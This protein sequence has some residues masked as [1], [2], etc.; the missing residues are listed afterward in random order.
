[1]RKITKKIKFSFLILF[2]LLGTCGIICYYTFFQNTLTI[3]NNTIYSNLLPTN[4]FK[5][6]YTPKIKFGNMPITDI[7]KISDVTLNILDETNIK[8]TPMLLKAQRYYI[9]LNF[10]CSKLKYNF[11]DS[12]GSLIVNNESHT[13]S[14][15]QDTYTKDSINGSLRGNLINYNGDYYIGISDIEK[16]FGLTAVFDFESKHISLLP[17]NVQQPKASSIIYSRKIALLRF[18]DFTN[19]DS[20]AV[21][22]NQV[23]VKCMAD[24][25]YSNGIKFHV[26]WIP[27]FKAPL[28]NIDNNLLE[29]DSIANVGFVNLLDYLINKGAE[30]GL[31]GYTHQSGTDR[32]AAGEELSK[33]TNNTVEATKNVIENGIDVASALNIPCTFYESPHYR[34]TKLQQSIIEEYFQFVYEPFD[35]SKKNIYKTNTNNL[36][37]PTP[38]GFV[39]NSD[40]SS[41]ING[42]KTYDPEKLH[43]FF[44]HPSIEIDYINFNTDNNKLNVQYDENSPLNKMSQSIKENNYT[45]VHIDELI[46][47]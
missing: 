20:M 34:D 46:N 28:D 9:P 19:G 16:L 39:E 4:T 35:N 7:S 15:T 45:T 47:K 8:N 1:M 42:L 23:K 3:I 36:Y 31:H 14:L 38:L 10:I 24:L 11:N 22:K 43:S 40:M 17:N 2:I 26:G 18:E 12:N 44:Y 41:I 29:N 25:L 21:D 32:S 33:D 30:M 37:V 5:S 27:R 6:T 13:I